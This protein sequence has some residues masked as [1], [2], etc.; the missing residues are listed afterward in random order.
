MMKSKY[1]LYRKAVE[2][3]ADIYQVSE[4]ELVGVGVKLKKRGKKVIYNLRENYPALVL[5]KQYIP[6][7]LRKLIAFTLNQ[8]LK[9]TLRRYD[10]VFSVTP[11]IDDIVCN[12]WGIRHTCVIANFPVVNRHNDFP[13]EEYLSRSDVVCYVGTVYNISCQDTVF[14]AL[15]G[16]PQVSYLIAGVMDKVYYEQLSRLDYWKNV[17]FINGFD[18]SQLMSIF[19]QSTVSNVIRDFTRTGTPNGSLGVIKMFE[20]MEAG[21]PII[22]SDVKLN[23]EIVTKY[24]CGICVD[25]G[26]VSDIRRAVDYLVTHK[27]EAYRMGQN[28]RRAVLEEY[29]WDSQAVKYVGLVKATW[30]GFV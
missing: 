5:D 27:E 10:A 17:K 25:P 22:C 7:S 15:E 9:K 23:R 18:K 30:N 19:A 6:K 24:R 3:D 13:V 8:Y 26:S 11:D 12:V 1:Y 14:A 28:G 16:L 21:L 2:L 20:S 29:N 4:P